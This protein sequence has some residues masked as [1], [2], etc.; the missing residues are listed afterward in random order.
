M[1]DVGEAAKFFEWGR[2][3]ARGAEVFFSAR[4]PEVVVC[5]EC[6]RELLPAGYHFEFDHLV[7][8]VDCYRGGYVDL[9]NL[10]YL[11]DN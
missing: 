5:V 2:V 8:F 6:D 10:F 9:F 7:F 3:G 1:V 4:A 11:F